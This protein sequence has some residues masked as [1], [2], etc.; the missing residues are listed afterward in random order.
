M[1]YITLYAGSTESLDKLINEAI[2]QGWKPQGGIAFH[3]IM[4][5]YMHGMIKEDP[6]DKVPEGSTFHTWEEQHPDA[7]TDAS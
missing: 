5:R 1:K 6:Q 2:Q 3:A 7:K 4:G